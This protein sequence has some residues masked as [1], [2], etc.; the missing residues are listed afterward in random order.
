MK[1]K[2]KLALREQSNKYFEANDGGAKKSYTQAVLA[3]D[4]DVFQKKTNEDYEMNI[5][6]LSKKFSLENEIEEM[7]FIEKVIKYNGGVS[8]AVTFD[9]LTDI[10]GIHGA[11]AQH[12]WLHN[13]VYGVRNFFGLD[14]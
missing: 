8:K 10:L 9:V 12:K 2:G 14:K 6:L 3:D 1:N 11:E 5:Y 7:M 13:Q 4:V